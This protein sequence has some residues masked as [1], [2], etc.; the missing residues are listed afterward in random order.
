M[1]GL[2]MRTIA[3]IVKTDLHAVCRWIRSFAESNYKKPT[4]KSSEV[5]VELDEILRGFAVKLA[6]FP[7]P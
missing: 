7:A 3:K 2:S 6:L 5:V 4:P 1:C